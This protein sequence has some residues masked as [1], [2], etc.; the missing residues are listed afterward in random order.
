[1]STGDTQ[2]DFFFISLISLTRM[3]RESRFIDFIFLSVSIAPHCNGKKAPPLTFSRR[4]RDLK[5]ESAGGKSENV[6]ID[7]GRHLF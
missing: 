4:D 7:I 3:G 1:M 2:H 6:V 5:I